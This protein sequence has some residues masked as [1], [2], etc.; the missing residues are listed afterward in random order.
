VNR[1]F[2]NQSPVLLICRA[3][4]GFSWIYQGAV[5][6]LLYCSAGETEL[7][8]HIIPV[9]QWACMAV[10]WMGIAEILFG[11]L[12]LVTFRTWLFW[13]NMLTLIGLLLF[14]AL[15]EPGMFT[16]PFNP[17]TLNTALIALSAVAVMELKKLNSGTSE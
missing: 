17:L 7:L 13:L 10:S 6:K 8:G 1:L 12:L 4:L 5:P 15:F 11:L 14:V 9:Y 16:L 3:A 2:S